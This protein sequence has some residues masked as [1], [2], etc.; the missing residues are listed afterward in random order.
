MNLRNGLLYVGQ[1]LGLGHVVR[2]FVLILFALGGVTSA[3]A[4]GDELRTVQFDELEQYWERSVTG[5]EVDS[6]VA[7]SILNTLEEGETA[8]ATVTFVIDE[9]GEV[10]QWSIEEASHEGLLVPLLK[11]QVASYS[12]RPASELSEP[13]PVRVVLQ[14]VFERY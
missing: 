11:G 14:D 13:V 8:H 7:Q 1:E 10:G 6:E 9:H 4:G 12:F 5:S 2:T 3:S